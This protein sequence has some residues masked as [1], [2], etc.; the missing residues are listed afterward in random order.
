MPVEPGDVWRNLPTTLR[1]QVSEDL[2]VV[3][4]E[5]IDG[6]GTRQTAPS[7]A[8][9]GDLRSTVHPASGADKPGEPPPHASRTRGLG[10]AT[11]IAEA[12][13]D[14]IDSDLAV[15]QEPGE[16]LLLLLHV[17]HFFE[18]GNA[19]GRIA[20]SAE[21]SCTAEAQISSRS[22]MSRTTRQRPVPRCAMCRYCPTV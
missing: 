19:S 17:P 13:I 18:P 7:P 16:C 3:L 4:R 15:P 12:D 11:R 5:I 14:V 20:L 1:R 8:T 2:A 9:G 21:R 22:H 6:L 10:A